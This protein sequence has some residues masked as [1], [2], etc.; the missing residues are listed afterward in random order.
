MTAK[1]KAVFLDRD[2]TL[3]A[4]EYYLADPEFVRLLPGAAAVLVELKKLGFL[5]VLVSNQSGIGRGLI[6]S[7]QAAQV[8]RRMEELLADC[9]VR[10]DAVYYCPHAPEEGC[11][12]RKPAPGML[13]RAAT[14]LGIELA[15]SIMI[16]DKMS[17]VEAATAAGCRPLLLEGPDLA[18]QNPS[19][20]WQKVILQIKTASMQSEPS[21]DESPSLNKLADPTWP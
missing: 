18:D 5:L 2:G 21:D 12:C 8:H 17:D 7:D 10:L 6:N 16:G 13:L 14:E 9:G 3:I 1:A 15:E 20:G 4:D 19:V 11:L